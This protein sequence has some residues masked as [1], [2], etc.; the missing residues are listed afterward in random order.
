M[1][2][3]YLDIETSPNAAHVWG[4]FQQNVSLSQL[5]EVA[6]MMCFAAKWRGSK[7]VEFHSGR[8]APDGDASAMV[9]AAHA[10]LDEADVVVHWNGRRFDVPHLNREFKEAGLAPP[11][12]FKQ[13]DLLD[14]VRKR[15]KLPSNKLAY[16]SEWLG[17]EGKV[18]HEG[19]G[20][21]VKC[22]A[23]DAAAWRRM[24][25]YNKRDVTLLEAIHDDLMP[26]LVG[27][28][29]VALHDGLEGDR[30]RVCASEDLRREGYAYTKQG[31]FRQYQCRQ[32]NSWSRS[33][34]R[35]ASVDIREVAA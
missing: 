4:L 35:E 2:V 23:G 18:S 13:L 31:K 11:S 33:G 24:R 34:R 8:Y 16:V 27:A 29:N 20:L 14:T 26:W 19:H 12:P 32:C 21:W 3:V 1:K 10:F 30:C 28:P 9:K 22:L 6:E 17:L 7:K 15:F 5:M 25:T